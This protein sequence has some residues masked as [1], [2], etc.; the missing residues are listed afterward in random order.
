MEHS[1]FMLIEFGEYVLQSV[2]MQ[3]GWLVE[4]NWHQAGHV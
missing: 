1:G 3:A 2:L 4:V